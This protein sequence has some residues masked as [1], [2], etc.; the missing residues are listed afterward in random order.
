MPI[1]V[2]LTWPATQVKL[3]YTK[4]GATVTHTVICG[5]DGK[6]TDT[7]TPDSSGQWTIKASWQGN[8]DHKAASSTAL[9]LNVADLS[10]TETLMDTGMLYVIP[11]AAVLA[12]SGV[13]VFSRRRRT[14]SPQVEAEHAS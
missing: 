7:F 12:L 10:F 13:I 2:S 3:E 6:F 11:V 5:V 9:S 8:D 14:Q 1:N 4:G